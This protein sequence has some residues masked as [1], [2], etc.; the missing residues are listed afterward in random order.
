[1]HINW[2]EKSTWFIESLKL[3]KEEKFML[4]GRE[5]HALT[6][7]PTNFLKVVILI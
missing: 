7:L 4:H 5:L 3:A 6:T 2:A 1:M